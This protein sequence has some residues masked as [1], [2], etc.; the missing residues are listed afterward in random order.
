M[1]VLRNGK[2]VEMP[3][4]APD[5]RDATIARLSAELEAAREALARIDAIIET[6]KV[7][8]AKVAQHVARA[9]LA[10]MSKGE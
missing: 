10:K 8:H 3:E 9:V 1:K 5:P 4:P 7:N 6:G 2:A